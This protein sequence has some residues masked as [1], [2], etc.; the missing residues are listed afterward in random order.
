MFFKGLLLYF[1]SEPKNKW[2]CSLFHTS[3]CTRSFVVTDW[4]FLRSIDLSC[5][6]VAQ[7]LY[8][9]LWKWSLG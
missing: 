8:Q 3:S 1:L 5:P 2:S 7:C 6:L 9:I 4:R